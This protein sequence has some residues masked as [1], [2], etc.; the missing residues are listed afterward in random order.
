[1]RRCEVKVWQLSNLKSL[2]LQQCYS[3]RRKSSSFCYDRGC[4]S[5]SKSVFFRYQWISLVSFLHGR[6]L[7]GNPHRVRSTVYSGRLP[8]ANFGSFRTEPR[9]GSS[10]VWGQMYKVFSAASLLS[11]HWVKSLTSPWKQTKQVSLQNALLRLS[12]LLVFFLFDRSPLSL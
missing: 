12:K 10:K 7:V 11:C 9:P 5:K 2:R 4:H 1:V 8:Q 3:H 6:S